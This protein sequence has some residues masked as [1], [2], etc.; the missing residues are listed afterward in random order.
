MTRDSRVSGRPDR[1]R[2][3]TPPVRPRR[4]VRPLVHPYQHVR[5]GE[6]GTLPV[7]EPRYGVEIE[8]AVKRALPG[9]NRGLHYRRRV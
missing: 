1:R 3:G 4:R 9:I 2:H 5:N 7:I 6:P 8:S